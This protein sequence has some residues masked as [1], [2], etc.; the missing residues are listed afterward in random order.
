MQVVRLLEFQNDTICIKYKMFLQNWSNT[1][2]KRIRACSVV[3]LAKNKFVL[4]SEGMKNVPGN[5]V[6]IM[7]D[8]SMIWENLKIIY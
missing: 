1:L 8:L 5:N 7:R 3:K 6:K 4:Q 2:Y